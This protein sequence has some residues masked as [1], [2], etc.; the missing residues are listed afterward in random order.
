LDKMANKEP[1]SQQRQGK[2]VKGRKKKVSRG[3]SKEKANKK[4]VQ[5]QNER[6]KETRKEGTKPQTLLWE[7]RKTQK[8][9]LNPKG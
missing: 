6:N 5:Y 8:E 4:A 2:R 9:R 7:N 3:R 1:P